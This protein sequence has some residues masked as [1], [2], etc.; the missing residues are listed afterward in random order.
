MDYED[1]EKRAERAAD[2]ELK[3]MTLQSPY[4]DLEEEQSPREEQ[5]LAEATVPP[6]EPPVVD[7]VPPTDTEGE[8]ENPPISSHSCQKMDSLPA[9]EPVTGEPL[10]RGEGIVPPE[11]PPVADAASSAEPEGEPQKPEKPPISP[12][13]LAANRANAQ[14]STGPKTPEGKDKA[15]FNA[16]KHGL[17]ARYFP[18]VI[19]PGT[20]ESEE[21]EFVRA[22]LSGH[23][24]PQ[25]PMEALLVA[26]ISVEYMRY[27]RLVEREQGFYD[28]Y[29]GF[30]PDALNKVAR[31]Q[32]AINRQLFE[33]VKEL[34][35]LQAK[36]KV[37]EGEEAE[38]KDTSGE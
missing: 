29:R 16:L 26:K 15:K 33:A 35:R 13:K 17:T 9:E 25:D 38:S 1:Q 2:E 6:E 30:H 18:A 32:T 4:A 7:A 28:L 24:Q 37:E 34:E 27:R 12:R 5:P 8:P 22:D 20:P 14:R 10:A 31:Y 23:Y 36:R 11:E 21:Y 19:K 3:E